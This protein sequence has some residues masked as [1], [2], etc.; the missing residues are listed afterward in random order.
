MLL[1][2]DA[3][4]TNTVFA[5]HNGNSWVAQ[6]RTAT[7]TTRT[8][9]ELVVWLSNLMAISGLEF[10]SITSC[11]ISCVVPQSL[12]H[13]R[14]LSKRYLGVHALVVGDAG[15]IIRLE[16]RLDNPAEAGADRLVNAV[17]AR[18]LHEGALLIIDSGTATTFDVIS[19]DGAFLG[20]VICPGINLSMV[21]LHEAAA[22]LPRIEIRRPDHYWGTNTVNAMQAG[23]YWGYIS[24]IEGMVARIIK[25]HDE[26]MT[27]IATGGV[28]SLFDGATNCIDV[29]DPD[30][31][32]NGLLEIYRNNCPEEGFV[33]V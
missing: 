16:N 21:A 30:L 13:F 2:I 31:T 26:P 8:A 15:T 4:N 23:V 1:A 19:A 20:G 29:Y 28:V 9:D 7:S 12:F 10:K 33:D 6:W 24:L 27:V 32:I 14:N 3:G 5:V 25:S 17:G 11:I 22:R 18:V